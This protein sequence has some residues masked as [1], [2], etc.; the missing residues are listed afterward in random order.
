MDKITALLADPN[1]QRSVVYLLTAAGV[2][3]KPDQVA[4]ILT[5]ALALIGV[6][7]AVVANRNTKQP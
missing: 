5:G 2:A 4:N 3:V 7:H 1:F 6:I